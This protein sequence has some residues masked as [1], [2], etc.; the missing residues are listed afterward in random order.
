[1]STG[2]RVPPSAPS[3]SPRGCACFDAGNVGANSGS[4]F[5]NLLSHKKKHD[6]INVKGGGGHPPVGVVGGY[7]VKL[8]RLPQH[9][10][11]ISILLWS[12]LPSNGYLLGVVQVKKLVGM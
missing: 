1:M 9:Q 7:R 6:R 12:I 4:D 5:G 3:A 10:E 8:F 2:E 11:E